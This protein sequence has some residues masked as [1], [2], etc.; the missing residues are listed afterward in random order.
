MSA[1][2]QTVRSLTE[3]S[4]LVEHKDIVISVLGASAGLSGFL[5]VFLGL[6]VS[7]YQG[8]AADT[9]SRVKDRYRRLGK[10]L[11]SV[12][13]IGVF[14]LG[15]AVASLIEGTD[16]CY[17]YVGTIAIFAIQVVGLVVATVLTAK[18]TL[19]G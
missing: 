1:F 2:W 10:W 19:W 15:L 18:R 4:S 13:I 11:L 5:L 9:P 14:C 16:N 6:L 7:A 8:Y 17:L 12:F 3:E